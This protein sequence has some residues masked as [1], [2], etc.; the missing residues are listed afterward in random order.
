ML[1]LSA[2]LLVRIAIG[3]A[4]WVLSLRAT[5]HLNCTDPAPATKVHPRVSHR[6]G[7]SINDDDGGDVD[8]ESQPLLL[9][10]TA[11]PIDLVPGHFLRLA[12]EVKFS[13]GRSVHGA[14][15]LVSCADWYVYSNLMCRLV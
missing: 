15:G 8:L 6:H 3:V 14:F 1:D 11:G 7:G 5:R 9:A 4:G 12:V 13:T 2:M 10:G